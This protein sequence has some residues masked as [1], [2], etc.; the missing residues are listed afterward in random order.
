MLEMQYTIG[1]RGS[2]LA[3]TQTRQVVSQLERVGVPPLKIK[4]ITTR[5]DRENQVLLTEMDGKDFFT[6]EL[7]QALIQNEV[8]LVVHSYKD[9]GNERPEGIELG[10][11]TQRIYPHDILLC[12]KNTVGAL[13]E[14][15][16]EQFQIGSCSPRRRY[17]LEKYLGEFLPFG[18]KI[19]VSVIPLRGNVTTRIKE[20]KKG[21]FDGVVLALAGL[22]RLAMEPEAI[23]LL[24]ELDYMVLP[25]SVFT[26]AAAQGALAIEIRQNC[27]RELRQAVEKLNHAV[28]QEE[29]SREKSI[30]QSYGGGCQLAV[31]I[32]V[33]KKK[34]FYLLMEKGFHLGEVIKSCRLIGFRPPPEGKGIVMGYADD[35][36]I[37]IV[38][39]KIPSKDFFEKNFALM[40]TSSYCLSALEQ[41]PFSRTLIASGV[42]THKK[43]ARKG[44]WVN[45]CGDSLGE[46]EVLHLLE[47]KFLKIM[48]NSEKVYVLTGKGSISQI[49]PTVPC[50]ERVAKGFKN[51]SLRERLEAIDSFYWM[52]FPQ[53]QMYLKRFP[54]I[55]RRQHA[56][57]LGKTWKSFLE[58]DIDVVPFSGPEEFNEWCAQGG[59]NSELFRKII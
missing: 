1:T 47:S 40:V 8:D 59:M 21:C 57:G 34:D 48:K 29:V 10:A 41:L 38:P 36:L 18:E 53:Y 30:F 46:D 13:R 31:G 22:E 28:T 45:L 37:E 26:P 9:L 52:S 32:H 24:T 23:S 33:Q 7:D 35:E 54:F 39:C 43:M 51:T 17:N 11:V 55:A 49:G 56:C 16:L 27:P 44:Y 19:K 14:C 2:L 6:K 20:L 58:K 50:Y 25:R 5:G 3:L 4:T 42:R 15:K 12:Q